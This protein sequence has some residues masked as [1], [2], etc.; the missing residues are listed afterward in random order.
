MTRSEISLMRKGFK[1]HIIQ[2]KFIFK[3]YE[4]TYNRHIVSSP[5]TSD[6][7]KPFENLPPNISDQTKD[8]LQQ[9]A[10]TIIVDSVIPSFKTIKRFF[11]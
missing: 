4:S 7:Y 2:P 5:E 3:G 1:E 11:E 6:F 9:V 8:S 10:K